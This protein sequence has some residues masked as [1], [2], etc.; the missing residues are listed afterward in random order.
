[1]T[2]NTTQRNGIAGSGQTWTERWNP[3]F[4]IF[5]LFCNFARIV[6]FFAYGEMKPIWRQMTKSFAAIKE[7]RKPKLPLVFFFD[8][9]IYSLALF[10]ALHSLV[11]NT[12]C[13]QWQVGAITITLAWINLLLQMRLLYGIGIY[14]IIFKD[15]V[16]T[17]LKISIV[18]FILLVGFAFSFHLLLSHRQEF[19]FPYDSMLKTIIM[20]SGIKITL[21]KP[22]RTHGIEYS[23]THSTSFVNTEY[24]N[25]L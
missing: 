19:K 7:W 22:Q 1:M 11:L 25:N 21:Q 18:F 13:F 23:L 24:F 3:I 5:L 12:S 15:V 8:F 20:M 14:I 16:L 10:L 2:N 9:V 4:R 6:F 17:F